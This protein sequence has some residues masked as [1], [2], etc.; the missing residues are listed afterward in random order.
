MKF[1]ASRIVIVSILAVILF[2]FAA[3][4]LLSSWIN[5][6]VQ[7]KISDAGILVE[8]LDVSLFRQSLYIKGFNW[9]LVDKRW[10]SD[11]TFIQADELALKGINVYKLWRNKSVRVKTVSLSGGRILIGSHRDT[12]SHKA[13]SPP[14]IKGL[15][16]ETVRLIDTDVR[17]RQDSATNWSGIAD[18]TLHRVVMKDS[19]EAVKLSSLQVV[20]DADI[21]VKNLKM[22]A[23]AKLLS[24]NVAR[25]TFNRGQHTLSCDSMTITPLCSKLAL[26]HKL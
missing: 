24:L 26:A 14:Q 16:I 17:W 10:E 9:T 4:I 23:N 1:S 11:S 25:V 18:V 19:A 2:L 6:K 7:Q 5:R 21:L 22:K 20:G 3:E 8:S 15:E 13:G 12:T